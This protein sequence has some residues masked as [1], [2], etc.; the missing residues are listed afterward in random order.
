MITSKERGM[1]DKVKE[2]LDTPDPWDGIVD[3]DIDE[4]YD[5]EVFRPSREDATSAVNAWL[6]EQELL[7]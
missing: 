3:D 5:P 2:L 1:E 4:G 7:I 6:A